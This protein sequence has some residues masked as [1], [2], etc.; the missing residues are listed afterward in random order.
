MTRHHRRGLPAPWIVRFGALIR[1]GGTVLDVACGS[2]RHTLHFLERGYHV[3]ASDIDVSRLD[4]LTEFPY[5]EIVQADLESGAWPFAG[6]TFDG[7]VVAN[8]L[9]RP[10]FPLLSGALAPGGVL[11]YETFAHG[12]ER[13][14]RPRN[15]DHLLRPGEL[16]DAFGPA[17]H[18]IAFEQGIIDP[19]QRAA[20]QRLCAGRAE[21]GDK[22]W[23]LAP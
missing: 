2:G 11:L 22:L 3:V 21:Q 1:T 20:I 16:L 4:D 6:R 14:G 17:L 10:L 9:Y 19:P 18:V 12:N 13:F 8:Y 23:P 15:P 5:L 7:I